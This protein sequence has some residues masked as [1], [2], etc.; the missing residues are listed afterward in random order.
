[1]RRRV[2]EVELAGYGSLVRGHGARELVE[3]VTGRPPVWS[4]VRRGWSIQETTARDVIAAAEIRNYD[5]L[6]IGPRQV[7]EIYSKPVVPVFEQADPGAG[8]W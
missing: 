5:I 6:V 8:L 2:L 1:M 3:L 7:E 4:S